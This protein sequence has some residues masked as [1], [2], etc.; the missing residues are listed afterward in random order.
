MCNGLVGTVRHEWYQVLQKCTWRRRQ[1]RRCR[2]FDN[3]ITS[4]N[5]IA[6]NRNFELYF[7]NLFLRLFGSGQFMSFQLL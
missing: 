5:K 3:F 1:R 7:L 2:Q 6:T 4:P